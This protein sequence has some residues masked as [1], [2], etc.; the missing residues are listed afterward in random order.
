MATCA[1]LS[2]LGPKNKFIPRLGSREQGRSK[3]KGALKKDQIADVVSKE[4]K[5]TSKQ[6]EATQKRGKFYHLFGFYPSDLRSCQSLILLMCRPTD[7]AS[8]GVVRALFGFLMVFDIPDERG[9]AIA[10][11][12]WGNPLDC[13]FPLF[14]FLPLLSLQW[15]FM[16]YLVMWIGA[17]GIT[18]GFFFRTSCVAFAS[19][20]WYIFL[21]DK[22]S[23]NNH[24]YLYGL[25]A[26]LLLPSQANLYCSL[27]AWIWPKKQ[28]KAPLWNYAILRYQ[29][30]LLY[31][32][33]GLKKLDFDWL[34]GYSM[35]Y[36]A[37][38]WV[39]QP[40]RTFMTP[41]Q[42]DLWIIHVGGFVL[43]LTVAFW[44]FFDK[45]RPSALFFCS[46]FHLMNSQIF[47]IGM[48]P[49][50]C[51]VTLPLFC[52]P[53]WPRK[54]FPTST[55][56]DYET[57]SEDPS[58]LK[59][60]YHK[61]KLKIQWKHYLILTCLASHISI[62]AVLPYS[63]SFTKG[64]KNWTPG[65]Y[66]YSWDMMVHSWNT[67]LVLPKVIDRSSGKEIFLNPDTDRW[68]KHP[69]MVYQWAKCV[70][71]NLLDTQGMND[72]SI[73]LDVL[74]SLNG[75]F[76]QRMYDPRVDLTK[77]VWSPFEEPKWTLPLLT[78][79]SSWRIKLP[80]IEN[81]IFAWSNYSDVLFVADF[82]GLS[83]ENF[84]SEGLGNISLTV[85]EGEVEFEQNT[86][87][88]EREVVRKAIVRPGEAVDVESKAFHHIKT[89]SLTPSCYM[90]TFVNETA[91]KLKNNYDDYVP[92]SGEI[93]KGVYEA[94]L[95][96]FRSIKLSGSLIWNAIL[97]LVFGVPVPRRVKITP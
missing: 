45:T 20:Y 84:I 5:E 16:V 8:L 25:L 53:S 31:F 50:V 85:L 14:D 79:L 15:M 57:G 88:S 12:R 30:F 72:V 95:I 7:A 38:H 70:Q 3:M 13:R 24:S 40:F 1:P 17:L 73:F 54:I 62:Q 93:S 68:S 78:D 28:K 81:Q 56:N 48:F 27:D 6:F 32:L 64:F 83:M 35:T 46:S 60:I 55:T 19:T 52:D 41:E 91:Q 44:L 9:L 10:D 11:I 58:C 67:I 97:N 2:D 96:R 39:F 47:S 87:L 77:V 4:S 37:N 34:N 21:M 76:Q 36:L 42:V 29:L 69:D 66:G 18:L 59:P 49:Y 80:E 75:R 23:W 65:L 82:P 86:L 26:I 74:S 51:L 22:S 94:I 71:K 89:I 33:A 63:H 43:D 61:D 90:Y 92:N